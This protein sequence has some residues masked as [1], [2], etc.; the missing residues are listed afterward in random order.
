[1]PF[2]LPVFLVLIAVSTTAHA[3]S[4]DEI[5]HRNTQAMGGAPAWAQVES[6]RF[7][8]EIREPGVEATATYIAAR[9]GR[10]RIDV[11]VG[12]ERV[13][14]EGLDGERAWQWTPDGGVQPQGAAGA[15]ALRHGIET[16][17][18]FHTLEQVRSRGAR[19]ELVATGGLARPGEWQVRVTLADGAVVDYFIDRETFL[20]TREV[21]RRAFHPDADP[22]E[23][24][25]E[26]VHGEPFFVDGVLRFRRS[27]QRNLDTGA[28]LGTTVVRSVSHGVEIE[29]ISDI[30]EMTNT[31]DSQ[32]S[33][34]HQ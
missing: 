15:A 23:V 22:T 18:K 2:R 16:P 10:M 4:L 9:D 21:S 34:L 25:V 5:L 32:S 19:V 8:L 7:E 13:Y 17:G 12:G 28:W 11:F 26:T 3:L 29:A 6:V 31:L 24:P 1:M 33:G 30:V 14:A 27:E 20:A